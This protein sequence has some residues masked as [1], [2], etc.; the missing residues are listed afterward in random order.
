[1]SVTYD[2][3]LEIIMLETGQYI[4]SLDVTLLDKP[5]MV[6][7]IRREL[8]LYSRYSPNVVTKTANLYNGKVFTEELDGEIPQAI[9]DIRTDR[10]NTI[11]FSITPM[12][13]PVHSYYWRYDKP[14]LKF[15]Y[16][17]GLYQL[18]Y[19]A[20][21]KFDESTDILPSIQLHDRFFSL[22]VGRF[23]MS[24]G[25]SRRAFSVAEMPIQT[26]ASEM[27]SEGKELYDSALEEIRMNSKFNLAILV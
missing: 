7:M 1:M 22:L 15:R 26:D 11:G 9:V 2:E 5:K 8:G 27:I 4:A 25:K 10:Y 23:L 13:S 16:P 20:P 12:P 14:V 17:D 19:M 24:V 6:M 21:H 3:A 18:V